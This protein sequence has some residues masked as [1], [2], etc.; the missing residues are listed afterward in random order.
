MGSS[1]RIFLSPPDVSDADR[2]A[3]LAAF[4]SGWVAPAGPDIDAFEAELAA[5]CGRSHAVA[6]SSGTAAI[7]LAL[8]ALGVGPGDEVIVPTL[9]FAATAN[10]VAYVGAR[11]VFVDV[12]PNDWTI[13]LPRLEEA[14]HAR[15]A[16]GATVKAVLPVDLYGQCADYTEILRFGVEHDLV[17]FADAAESLGASRDGIRAGASGLAAALSFNG[18]KIITTSG[19]G[20]LV[21]DDEAVAAHVKYL[22]TQARQPVAHY[23]HTDVGFNYRLSN[24]LAGL[25]R[26]Q[27]LDLPR[28]IERRRAIRNR[29]EAALGDVEGLS[30]MPVPSSSSPNWWLTCVLLPRG[31]DPD[32]VRLTLEECN[33][34]TRRTWKPLH[35]QPVFAGFPRF[36]DGTSDAIWAHGLCLPSGSSLSNEQLD[37]VAEQLVGALQRVR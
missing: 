21:T 35:L 26:S 4:D 32:L 6:L 10:P 12:D 37:C 17:V 3:L 7:H 33:I 23:E 31:C 29:Y 5:Q 19:G 16:A 2:R 30:L 20:A 9:T 15:R 27:L 34:E 11:P 1:E 14:L 18:N 25:G 13:S 22:S 36:L 24:L 8:L 28:R